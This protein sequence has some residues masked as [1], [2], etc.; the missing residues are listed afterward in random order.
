[1]FLQRIFLIASVLL[2]IM[3]YYGISALCLF[4]F[5]ASKFILTLGK[6]IP[7]LELIYFL[8]SAQWLLG[9]FFAYRLPVAFQ[10][11]DMAVSEQDYYLVLLPCMFAFSLGLFWIN[12]KS[13]IK[14]EFDAKLVIYSKRL[15]HQLMLTGLMVSFLGFLV[16]SSLRFAAYLVSGMFFIGILI[17]Y[18]NE[19]N[20]NRKLYLFMGLIWLLMGAAS[21][22][23]FHTLILWGTVFFC[24][25]SIQ[26]KRRPLL[27]YGLIGLGIFS[28]FFLQSI[29]SE[30]RSRANSSDANS[31]SVLYDVAIERFS[32]ESLFGK[33]DS[34]LASVNV[35]LNQGWIIAKIIDYVPRVRPYDGGESILEAIENSILPRFLNPNKKRAGGQENFEKYTG[36]ILD[37]GTSMGISVVGE[38]YANFGA[39]AWAFMLLWGAFLRW[40]LNILLKWSDNNGLIYFLIPLIFL[41]VI[42]AET[43]LYVV[44]N[45]LLKTLM[46]VLVLSP[47]LKKWHNRFR[48]EK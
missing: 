48:I 13:S 38:A 37:E 43:E 17:Y 30:F 11:Y 32:S 25:F 9:P 35:R 31:I 26:L 41:Q 20:K 7:I 19:N 34:E 1:M 42:K 46:L 8:A 5:S 10:K 39:Y 29:K 15:A 6:K 28:L 22:G 4:A 18:A 12:Q 24:F 16:P 23:I 2:F 47:I 36:E 45:H 44:L 3:G 40:V 33:D 14:N 21:S 27:K